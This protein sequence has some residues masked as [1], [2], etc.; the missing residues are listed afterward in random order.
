MNK[1]LQNSENIEKQLLHHLAQRSIASFNN[2]RLISI[3]SQD[4]HKTLV[5]TIQEYDEDNTEY[6]CSVI[7]LRFFN[8]RYHFLKN[9]NNS[10]FEYTLT[11][12][13]IDIPNGQEIENVSINDGLNI[14]SI[15]YKD[16]DENR[17]IK[18]FKFPMFCFLGKCNILDSLINID[19]RFNFRYVR[20]YIEDNN[21][22]EIKF[23][24]TDPY[25]DSLII[26]VDIYNKADN[27]HYLDLKY[28]YSS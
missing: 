21:K 10:Y 11:P 27:K 8:N 12:S 19:S 3:Y 7:L 5:L 1:P 26:E 22:L 24:M 28:I 14:I 4:D 17:F 16:K 9:K 23:N 6:T 25:Y 15:I 2:C 13:K 18:L 20:F